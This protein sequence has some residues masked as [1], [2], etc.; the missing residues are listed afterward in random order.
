MKTDRRVEYHSDRVPFPVAVQPPLKN[1]SGRTN[2]LYRRL[3]VAVR[4]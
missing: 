2:P 3:L 1:S 4:G